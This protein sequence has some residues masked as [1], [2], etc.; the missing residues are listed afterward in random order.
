MQSIIFLFRK[1][2]VYYKRPFLIDEHESILQA[3]RAR[4]ADTAERLMHEHLQADLDFYLH[5][6]RR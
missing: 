2:V 5:L 4:D 1:A 3:I 6:G